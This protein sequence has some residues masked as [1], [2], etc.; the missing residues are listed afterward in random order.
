MTCVDSDVTHNCSAV[1]MNARIPGVQFDSVYYADDTILFSTQP[2]ALNELLLHIEECS[3]HYRFKINRS[4]C[5]SIHM[6]HEAIIHFRDGA[7]SIKL[8]VQL[9]WAII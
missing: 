7:P 1:V 4:K 9:T 6:Y 5:H 8:M 3:E 2:S